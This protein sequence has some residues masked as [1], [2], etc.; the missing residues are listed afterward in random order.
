MLKAALG[1]KRSGYPVGRVDSPVGAGAGAGGAAFEMGL[2]LT[3]AAA[4]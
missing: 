3:Q 2:L 1:M 4:A